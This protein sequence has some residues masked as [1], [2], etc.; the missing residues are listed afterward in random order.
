[1]RK[2]FYILGI[3]AAVLFVTVGVGL[4]IFIYKGRG[5]DAESKAYVAA[6][7]PAITAGWSQQELLKRASPELRDSIKPGQ[8]TALFGL[9]SRLGPLVSYEGATGEANMSYFTGTGGTVSATYVAKA[10]YQNGE[11]VIRIVL[12]KRDGQW[13]IQNFHL[14]APGAMPGAPVQKQT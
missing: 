7:V 8:L 14:D 3:I 4:G 13:M 2:F 5:L 1:V 11:A 12:L 9:F 6:A 10:K